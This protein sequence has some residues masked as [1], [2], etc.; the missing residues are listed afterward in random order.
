[1]LV[2]SAAGE[3]GHFV[4]AAVRRSPAKP[5]LNERFEV[6]L[7]VSHEVITDGAQRS[8]VIAYGDLTLFLP[9]YAQLAA[10]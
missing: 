9:R 8:D 10:V 2:A 7:E 1:M 4:A 6:T 5:T 3:D